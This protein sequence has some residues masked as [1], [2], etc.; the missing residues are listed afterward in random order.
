M[1]QTTMKGLLE[2]SGP[3][4]GQ[5]NIVGVVT[6]CMAIFAWAI[7]EY[8]AFTAP[9]YIWTTVTGLLL[10]GLQYLQWKHQM[11]YLMR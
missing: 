10:Y 5:V 8:T 3:G 1:T 7:T 11:L 9:E 4:T 6:G 2:K